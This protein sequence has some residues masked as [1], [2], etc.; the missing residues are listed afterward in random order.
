MNEEVLQAVAVRERSSLSA[1]E[2]GVH[3]EGG[4]RE[5]GLLAHRRGPLLF[6]HPHERNGRTICM[7]TQVGLQLKDAVQARS[8]P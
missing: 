5:R 4:Q 3:T 7:S 6:P 2:R 8:Y 1:S